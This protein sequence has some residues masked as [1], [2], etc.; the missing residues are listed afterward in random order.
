MTQTPGPGL[1]KDGCAAALSRPAR[2][3]HLAVLAAFA[4]TGRPP[5]RGELE[6][7]ARA[8]GAD[9]GAVLAELAERDV[10]AFDADGEIRA[11]YP[12][13]PAPTPIQVSWEGGPVTYAMC[14]STRWASRPCWAVR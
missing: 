13:S 4:E 2:Q 5:A 12:F 10:I 14:P 8:G 3:A 7:I 1:N 6:R 9:P 11:A